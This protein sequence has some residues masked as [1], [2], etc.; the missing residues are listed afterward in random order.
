MFTRRP[1]YWH[2]SV[3][4][5]LKQHVQQVLLKL[6]EKQYSDIQWLCLTA[7]KIKFGH[8]TMSKVFITVPN[9]QRQAREMCWIV[10]M[11]VMSHCQTV[12]SR[13]HTLYSTCLYPETVIK[14]VVWKIRRTS[15]C[16][17]SKFCT[18][19]QSLQKSA[20][21]TLRSGK[22]P[23]YH[24]IFPELQNSVSWFYRPFCSGL[25]TFNPSNSQICHSNWTSWIV[26]LS[27]SI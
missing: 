4:M 5:Q 21:Q 22:L 9:A 3:L 7:L 8:P 17:L 23:E 24:G 15:N 1:G 2:N 6:C 13:K 26:F 20:C 14:I 19:S 18:S 25:M 11:E 27:Q 12:P 10:Q 16:S